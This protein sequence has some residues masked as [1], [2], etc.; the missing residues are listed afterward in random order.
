[1]PE[2]GRPF[3][4]GPL[5]DEPVELGLGDEPV[6]APVLLARTGSPSLRGDREVQGGVAFQELAHHAALPHPG[7][8]RDDE[9]LPPSGG[10]SGIGLRLVRGG[11]YVAPTSWRT[12]RGAR[13]AAWTPGH[14][15]GGSR[16]CRAAP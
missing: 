5:G 9:Q 12:P 7:G 14:G 2:H 3:Q 4:E 13:C 6:V 11:A 16:R 15:R 10:R 8:T 1:M